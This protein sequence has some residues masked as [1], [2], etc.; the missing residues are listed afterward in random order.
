MLDADEPAFGGLGDVTWTD[1]DCDLSEA[2]T[3][4]GRQAAEDE[5]YD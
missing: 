5:R 4:F 2:A 3:F 1:H